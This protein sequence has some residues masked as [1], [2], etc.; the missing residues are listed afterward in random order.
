[1][2]VFITGGNG[3][4]PLELSEMEDVS[5]SPSKLVDPQS[6]IHSAQARDLCS[7]YLE[8]QG[9]QPLLRFILG[10]R[11]VQRVAALLHKATVQLP[12]L[13]VSHHPIQGLLGNL[14]CPGPGAD[15]CT[16]LRFGAHCF[17]SS[18]G[19]PISFALSDD[20]LNSPPGS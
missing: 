7:K 2:P 5:V 1:M 14:F 6:P 11:W 20:L 19:V 4:S 18:W 17:R 8:N 10:R 16:L 12:V 9:S 15:Q 3:G 13:R